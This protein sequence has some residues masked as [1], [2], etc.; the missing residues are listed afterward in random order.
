[1][2]ENAAGSD[3]SSK[4]NSKNEAHSRISRKAGLRLFQH[5]D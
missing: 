3:Y 2:A 5:V 4:Q 1:L